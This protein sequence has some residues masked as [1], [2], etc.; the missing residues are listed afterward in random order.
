MIKT[1]ALRLWEGISSLKLT[2]VLLSLLMALVFLCTIAQVN[3]GT[4]GA[5]STYMRSLIVWWRPQA[6]PFPLPIFPGG[7]R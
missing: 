2:I 1:Y 4:F 7:A 3:M 6:L 5:V